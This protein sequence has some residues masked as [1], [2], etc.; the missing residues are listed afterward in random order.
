MNKLILSVALLMCYICGY[1][2]GKKD[3]KEKNNPR[4]KEVKDQIEDVR[5]EFRRSQ[6]DSC[7]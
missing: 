2:C 7:L 3:E 4:W 5:E 1:D 6:N